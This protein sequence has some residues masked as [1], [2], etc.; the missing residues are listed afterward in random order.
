MFRSLHCRL[1]KKFRKK[2]KQGF[3]YG[4]AVFGWFSVSFW[5]V[6]SSM[7]LGAGV[8]AMVYPIHAPIASMAM[9][10][11]ATGVAI[12]QKCTFSAEPKFMMLEM[13]GS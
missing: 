3:F 7:G 4:L 5:G 1:G 10:A 2:N 12:S 6:S 8:V 11:I 13:K 9:K